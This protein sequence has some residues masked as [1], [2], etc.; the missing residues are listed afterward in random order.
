MQLH[1]NQLLHVFTQVSTAALAV[2][3]LRGIQRQRL[4][5][6]GTSLQTMSGFQFSNL[7]LPAV[8]C[9][10]APPRCP[11]LMCLCGLMSVQVLLGKLR[12][13]AVIKMFM[14][15]DSHEQ[16]INLCAFSAQAL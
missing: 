13:K 4:T 5:V 14:A 15:F 2:P 11:F 7:P 9:F 1:T 16:I 8:H 3:N 10:N 6:T 12:V